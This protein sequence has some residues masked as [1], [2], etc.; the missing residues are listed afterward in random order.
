[1]ALNPKVLAVKRAEYIPAPF[2]G[3]NESGCIPIG[4]RVLVRPDIAASS[5]GSLALPDAVVERAQL[6]AS[7]GVIVALGDDAFTWNFDRTRPYA[8]EKPQVGDRIFMDVY[9]GKVI[10]GDDGVEYRLVDDKCIGGVRRK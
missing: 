2:F 1:M 4:D 3:T 5:S 9:S 8:G 7:S 6:S 10:L